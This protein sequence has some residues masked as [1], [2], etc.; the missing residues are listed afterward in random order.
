MNYTDAL[1]YINSLL[2]F[3]IKP[4]LSRVK[5]LLALM[6]NPQDSLKFVHVAGTNGKGSICNYISFILQE[7]GYKTGLFI[8]PFVLNFRERMQIGGRLISEAE[9]AKT[10]EHVKQFADQMLAAGEGLTEFELITA[11]AMMWFRRQNFDIVVLEVGL[12]G[13]FDATNVIKTTILSV[14]A[15]ISLDHTNILG[16]S[17]L[18]ITHEKCGIIKKNTPLVVYPKQPKGVISAVKNHAK[19]S[20]CKVILPSESHLFAGERT[21]FGSTF[22]YKNAVYKINLPGEH[23]IINA[24][25]A[26]E[27]ANELNLQ[28]FKISE[29]A[30]FCGLQNTRFIA[31]LEP[32]S[33]DPLVLLDGTHNPGG[34][35]ALCDY[36]CENFSGKK[37][38]AIVG[39]LKDKDAE[40]VLKSI[41]P[42]FCKVI[43]T[44]PANPRALSET[45]LCSIAKKYCNNTIIAKSPADA[46]ATAQ[47]ELFCCDGLIVFGSLYLASC[48]RPILLNSFN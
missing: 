37:L 22:E 27:A 47:R 20:N 14:I 32:I 39:M 1:N 6:G 21:A 17:I 18:K 5:K 45:E 48:I 12:G 40:C 9:L 34:A 29:R 2:K 36:I 38:I 13:R 35:A 43:V 11:A 25:T 44:S 46:V 33:Q 4:G 15:S 30:I 19:A 42:H 41:L 10:I 16:D 26:I 8:S 23:Q 7:A 31:R 24:V 3:G 28:G